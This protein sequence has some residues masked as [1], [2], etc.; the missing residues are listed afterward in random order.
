LKES[1]I[2][3]KKKELKDNTGRKKF[4]WKDKGEGKSKLQSKNRLGD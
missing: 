3:K 1:K 4:R 2:E